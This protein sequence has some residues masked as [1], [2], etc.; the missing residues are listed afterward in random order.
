MALYVLTVKMLK[1]RLNIK[2]VQL[3][4]TRHRKQNPRTES[5]NFISDYLTQFSTLQIP[6]YFIAQGVAVN[7]FQNEMSI[8]IPKRILKGM[9]REHIRLLDPNCKATETPTHFGLLTPLTGC[10]TIRRHTKSAIVYSNK[11]LEIPL[12]NTD[13]ITRVREIEIPFSCYYSNYGMATAV[14][15][16]PRNRKLV[17]SEK[18]TG[19]FTVLLE[20]YHSNR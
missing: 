15:L 19:N 17:F 14:G 2:L 18:G 3:S 6:S 1:K 13:I 11:V 7:C 4:V 20:L 8:I 12:K 10:N 9:D 5:L 16:K